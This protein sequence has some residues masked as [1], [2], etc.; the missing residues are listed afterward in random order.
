MTALAVTQALKDL[1]D[2]ND[3]RIMDYSFN[4]QLTKN[5]K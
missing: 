1:H 4:L 3:R 5:F 2:I